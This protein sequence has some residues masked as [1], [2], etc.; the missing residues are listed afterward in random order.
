M[1]HYFLLILIAVSASVLLGFLW[2]SPRFGLGRVW[3]RNVQ[4]TPEQAELVHSRIIASFFGTLISFVFMALVIGRLTE[5]IPS[6]MYMPEAAAYLI[7]GWLGFIVPPILSIVIWEGRSI[8]LFM[9]NAGYWLTVMIVMA[10]V[11]IHL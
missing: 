10:F 7:F 4:I 5:V 11:L 1:F 2:Y 6:G 8:K 3:M 9:V